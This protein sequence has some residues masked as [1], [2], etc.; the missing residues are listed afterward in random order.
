MRRGKSKLEKVIVTPL[1]DH[2][3]P[4]A[5]LQWKVFISS[6]IDCVLADKGIE[7]NHEKM[8]GRWM[9]SPKF[10][11]MFYLIHAPSL[12][13][14]DSYMPYSFCRDIRLT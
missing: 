14:Q 3:L 10:R 11:N 6:F 7:E 4:S 13:V 5:F 9:D 8:G 2:P 12:Q 1:L